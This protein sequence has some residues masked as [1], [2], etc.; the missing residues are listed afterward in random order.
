[1]LNK[2]GNVGVIVGGVVTG[3]VAVILLIGIL[4]PI[5]ANL[6]A[7]PTARNANSTGGWGTGA[8]FK[9]LTGTDKTIADNL[10]TFILI[11]TLLTIIALLYVKNVF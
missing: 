7:E 3:I 1:M 9:T 5:T 11:G 2:K 10:V 6:T 4:A 8:V